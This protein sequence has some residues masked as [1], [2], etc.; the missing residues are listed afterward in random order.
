MLPGTTRPVIISPTKPW[1]AWKFSRLTTV[2]RMRP[3]RIG[4]ASLRTRWAAT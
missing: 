3:E 1:K 2:T 4:L